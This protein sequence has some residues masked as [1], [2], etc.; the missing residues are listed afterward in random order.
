MHNSQETPG[1]FSFVEVAGHLNVSPDTLRRL[2]R[3]FD[4]HLSDGLYAAESH[5]SPA[6]VATLVTIQQLLNQGYADEHIHQQLTPARNDDQNKQ[7]GKDS[8]PSIIDSTPGALSNPAAPGLPK[9]IND[10]LNTIVNG[11]QAVLSSQ[12]SVRDMMGVVVQDNFNLKDENRKLRE[13]MLELER[14]LAE[15]QRREEGRKERTENRLRALEAT[16]GA[17]QQQVAQL[18]QAQRRP[19]QRG[20]FG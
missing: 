20:W 3:R 6:D 19:K 5:F 15:Y 14:V 9:A 10:V 17:L 11:Q 18:V 8:L 16:V 1:S 2:T 13:R 12:S 4:R 7:T